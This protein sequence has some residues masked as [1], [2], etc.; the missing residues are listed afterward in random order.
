[1]KSPLVQ[2]NSKG[3]VKATK[4]NVHFHNLDGVSGHNLASLFT[5]Q[6]IFKPLLLG[7]GGG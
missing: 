1:M 2:S 4:M 5:L 7:G 6:T 3:H